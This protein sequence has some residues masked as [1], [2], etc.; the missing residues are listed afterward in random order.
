MERT[1]LIAE[2]SPT[3]AER[4]RLL[5]EGEGYRVEV[6]SNGREGVERVRVATP[7]LIISDVN[8]P[9]M[10]GY[11]FCHAV[12][13]DKRGRAIP[14]VLLTERNTPMDIIKGL[15]RGTDNFITKPYEDDYVLER[16]QRIFE[17]LERRRKGQMEMEVSLRVGGREIV[18]STDKQQIIELLFATSEELCQLNA[19]L[20]ESER[21][22]KDYAQ[23]LEAQ[24]QERT[25]QLLQSEKL[26]TMGALL[27]GVAHELNNPLSVIAG[28]A[29]LL[30]QTVGAGPLGT[31]AEKIAKAADRCA[32]IV[33]N[34]LALARQHPPERQRVRLNLVVGEA[35]ELLAY[36][37]RVDNVEV[38]LELAED[39]PILWADPHQLHQVVV[40]LVTNAHYAMRG[41]PPPRRLT[42]ATLYH[43]AQ[44]RVSLEVA[45]TGP[46]IPPAVQARIFEPF[47]TTKPSGEGTG[48]GLSLCLEIVEAHGGTIRVESQPGR[49]A[50]FLME[51]PVEIPP[52]AASE[53]QANEALP[54]IREKAILVVD[55]E[56]EIAGLLAEML[57]LEGHRVETAG[58]GVIALE[59]LRER[60][61]DVILSDMRMPGLDGPGLY[62]EL[63]RHHPELV[64]RFISITGDTLSPETREF[65]EQTEA[66]SL[67]KPFVMDDVRRVVQQILRTRQ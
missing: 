53:A 40:N 57:S 6:V 64:R 28:Q 18:L 20:A 62:R 44:G 35:V 56:P 39:L 17:Q 66:P 5:L 34:F 13:S 25:R 60:A 4:L 33:K 1:I 61:Y 26:A 22:V 3:Q 14:F 59:K 30:R 11:S 63:E 21:L 65:L 27:A 49:G 55:D 67:S 32:R 50:A 16:V 2:D 36:P 46:G 19:R 15:E 52:V 51:L 54:P 10:D 31:R 48:L 12:K 24:V 8:M 7:D 29:G 45:D 47:F 43:P 41:N 23:T 37:L 38:K 9:E 58:S 42:L